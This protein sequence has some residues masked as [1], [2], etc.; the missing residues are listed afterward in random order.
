M[1][2][3]RFQLRLSE[4]NNEMVKRVFKVLVLCNCGLFSR[5]SANGKFN[6]RVL[7]CVNTD[8]SCSELAANVPGPF[9]FAFVSRKLS[10]PHGAARYR[11]LARLIYPPRL[12][13]K[14]RVNKR[15]CL[16]QDPARN[17]GPGARFT[18]EFRS[19]HIRGDSQ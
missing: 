5:F 2:F 9:S 4:R 6:L 3:H 8:E 15:R 7:A 11:Q 19:P 16:L 13:F 17:V 1:R 10:F 18:S 12:V 14:V